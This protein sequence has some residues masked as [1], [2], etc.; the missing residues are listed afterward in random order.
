MKEKRCNRISILLTDSE[1]AA[2]QA[3]QGNYS[4]EGANISFGF[5]FRY[6]LKRLPHQSP[7]CAFP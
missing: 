7:I 1:L 4:S 2:L 6:G 3:L 5:L